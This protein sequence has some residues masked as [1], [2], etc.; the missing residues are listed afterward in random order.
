MK[1]LIIYHSEHHQN[2]EKIAKAMAEKIGTEV[3]KEIIA[4]KNNN[5][6]FHLEFLSTMNP[7][8]KV[9]IR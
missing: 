9:V 5:L 2:T 7:N 4:W 3:I 6:L 1:V 8:R